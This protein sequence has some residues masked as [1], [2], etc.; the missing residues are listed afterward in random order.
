MKYRVNTYKTLLDTYKVIELPSQSYG[1]WIIYQNKIPKYHVNLFNLKHE[2]NRIIKEIIENQKR[3]IDQ[4]IYTINKHNNLNL[5]LEKRKL[6]SIKTTS[7]ILSMVLNPIPLELIE[8][9]H[10]DLEKEKN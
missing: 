1:E 7:D 9:K 10:L 6:L 4:I 8:C 2:S 3:S 5:H